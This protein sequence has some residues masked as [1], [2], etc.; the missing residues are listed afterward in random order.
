[1]QGD[2]G[3]MGSTHPRALTISQRE[4]IVRNGLGDREST[5]RAA[6]GSL[7]G[8]WVDVVSDTEPKT[9][10]GA[11]DARTKV[12]SGVV[13]LLKMLDLGESAVAA[14][15]LLSVFVT[16]VDIFDNIEFGGLLLILMMAD[17]ISHVFAQMHTGQISHRRPPSSR[18]FL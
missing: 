18:V 8:K 13:A 3:V 14:D 7:I 1:M 5:V 16:R 17:V 15:A 6:A 9:D 11:A 12:E 2:T 10:D 4:L